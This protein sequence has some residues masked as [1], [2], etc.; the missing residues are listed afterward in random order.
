MKNNSNLLMQQTVTSLYD[1]QTVCS[2]MKATVKSIANTGILIDTGLIVVRAQQAFSCLV[3]P[4]IGDVV[5]VN[6][7]A[8]EFYIL[9]ILQRPSKQD[10][11]LAFPADVQIQVANGQCDSVCRQTIKFTQCR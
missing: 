7:Q 8:D 10:M 11:Q 3:S 5:L 4:Q 6:R 2:S 1:K 9:A